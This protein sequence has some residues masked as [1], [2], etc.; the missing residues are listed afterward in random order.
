MNEQIIQRKESICKTLL[1]VF[2][3]L[4]QCPKLAYVRNGEVDIKLSSGRPVLHITSTVLTTPVTEI[5]NQIFRDKSP[6][7]D[8][9]VSTADLAKLVDRITKRVN[10][11]DHIGFCYTTQ[12]HEKELVNIK[13][14]LHDL[15]LY[16]MT[17]N[18]LAKWYFVGDRNNWRDPMVELLPTLL[19]VDPQLPYYLPHIHINIET[20]LG[21]VEI[22]NMMKEIFR[23]TRLP[24][25]FSHPT[26]GVYSMRLWLGTVSGVNI[27]LDIGTNV[28][29]L[30]WIR[31]HML[32]EI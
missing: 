31:A 20:T 16:E 11:L 32:Y 10:G 22:E 1:E 9:F 8:T 12:S 18:D 6:L 29:N 14:A 17:S 24:A 26:Y 4:A 7:P 30:Q 3:L 2:G 21:W 5:T 19:N 13:Q 25:K 27:M 28:N 23:D 15:H